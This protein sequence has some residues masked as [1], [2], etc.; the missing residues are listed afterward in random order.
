MFSLDER[1]CSY[2]AEHCCGSWKPSRGTRM[3]SR[4]HLTALVLLLFKVQPQQYY[5]AYRSG[6]VG[7]AAVPIQPQITCGQA[8]RQTLHLL[9]VYTR[10]IL[11]VCM[12]VSRELGPSLHLAAFGIIECDNMLPTTEILRYDPLFAEDGAAALYDTL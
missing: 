6:R 10:L 7:A 2:T 1:S 12:C 8:G 5:L 11:D 4:S 3:V 9:H